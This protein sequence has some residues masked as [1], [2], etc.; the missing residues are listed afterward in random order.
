MEML[1]VRE[2]R[3]GFIMACK[4]FDLL[5]YNIKFRMKRG[6]FYDFEHDMKTHYKSTRIMNLLDFKRR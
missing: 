5:K 2:I 4:R 6:E 3:R 1:G